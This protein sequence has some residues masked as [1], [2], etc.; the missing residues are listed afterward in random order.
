M[1]PIICSSRA[2]HLEVIFDYADLEATSD[3]TVVESY[4]FH[5]DLPKEIERNGR[6]RILDL[7]SNNLQNWENLQVLWYSTMNLM[8]V[9]ELH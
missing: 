4:L 6:L 8:I 5:Q 1:A 9:C 3:L 2:S 7:G